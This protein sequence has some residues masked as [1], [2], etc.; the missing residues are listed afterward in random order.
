MMKQGT[1]DYILKDRLQRLPNA[2]LS[3]YHKYR[4][5][6][7]NSKYMADVIANEALLKEASRLAHFGSWETDIFNKKER[8]SDEL[9]RI[10]GYGPGEIESTIENFFSRV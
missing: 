10:L 4:L 2:I 3:A 1:W 9:Y 5:A 8:W 6:T 7:E